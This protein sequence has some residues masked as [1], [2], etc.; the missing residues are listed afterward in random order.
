MLNQKGS[1][2]IAAA[3]TLFVTTLII[4]SFILTK[5][6]TKN[7]SNSAETNSTSENT[8]IESV[9]WETRTIY[10]HGLTINVPSS[11]SLKDDYIKTTN[12]SSCVY[13]L[14]LSNDEKAAIYLKP[15]C[16]AAEVAEDRIQGSVVIKDYGDLSVGQG[17]NKVILKGELLFNGP[18]D[19]KDEYIQISD[20]IIASIKKI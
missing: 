10:S 19:K 4:A 2:V 15:P 3:G 16:Q 12:N 18:I 9:T 20:K 11:W 5:G 8:I 14:V 6:P 7:S 1:I 17:G 13:F